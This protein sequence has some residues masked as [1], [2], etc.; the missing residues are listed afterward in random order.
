MWDDWIADAA[1][2]REGAGLT[3]T[4]KPRGPDDG[5]IDL[6]GNDYLGLSGHPDVRRAAAEAAML[7]GGGAGASRLVTGTLTLHGDLEEELADWLGQ[8]GALTF[9]TGY[10]A[11]L[12]IVSALADRTA[13]VV[14]DA[15]IHAS[16]IDAVRLSRAQLTVVPHNDV[17]AV[18]AAL[19]AQP[20]VRTLVL[21][22]SV[23]SVLGDEAPLT[24]LA[25]VCAEHGALLVVDE[26]HGVGV[27]GP[28][29][30]HRRG[31]A[32]R[33]DVL[34]TATLSKSLGSQG[35]AVLGP[36]SVLDHLVNTAR[37]FIFDTGLAPAA[38][39]AALAAAQ[40]ARSHPH[41]ADII[42]FRVIGL[43]RT[44]GV[45]AP[46][47]AVLSVPM[48]SPEGAVA[49]Q[50]ALLTE[51]VRVGCFRP[52]SVPDGVSRL[53]VTAGASVTDEEWDRAAKV[54]ETIVGEVR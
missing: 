30:V 35:G 19:A 9:S 31:L 49:A 50:A 42:R 45:P 10:H 43:A 25:E 34:V 2:T 20:G 39:A 33:P 27:H 7:W 29:L 48:P 37:P 15:H 3:R 6:A 28:G 32:G 36:R 4:L 8:P 46:A 1:A 24:E 23:Y 47:G 18:R 53:R 17:A 21:A 44:L 5:V 26:A 40:I 16:L 41:L 22:E 14:S 38:T 13:H 51:G 52:P 54:I 12:S 11:N